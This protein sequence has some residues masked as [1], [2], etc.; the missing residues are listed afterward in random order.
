MTGIRICPRAKIPCDVPQVVFVLALTIVAA[1][2]ATGCAETPQQRAQR[3]E[4][5]L[6]AAG[7]HI[8]PADTPQRQEE[9]TSMTPLKV[10]YY[11]RNGKLHYWFADPTLCQCIYVGNEQSYQKYEQIRLQQQQAQ[12]EEAAAMMN[13][14]AA[15]QEQMNF[16][17]WPGD[18]F[19]Y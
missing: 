9:L 11:A 6:S 19:F 5:M 16:M 13:E 1:W 8:H 14:D 3:I 18:P 10:R 12:R 7:F 2:L 17:M 15:Q 4:P